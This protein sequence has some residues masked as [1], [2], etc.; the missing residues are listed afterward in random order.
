MKAIFFDD[1]MVG[2]EEIEVFEPSAMTGFVTRLQWVA[3][4]NMYLNVH[5]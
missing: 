4:L 1:M 2:V 5:E 3:S